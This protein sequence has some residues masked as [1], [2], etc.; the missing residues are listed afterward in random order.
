MSPAVDSVKYLSYRLLARD[1]TRSDGI[2]NLAVKV[3]LS[4]AIH[5]RWPGDDGRTVT[6]QTGGS[7]GTHEKWPSHDSKAI[8]AQTGGSS[9]THERWSSSNSRAETSQ[10]VIGVPEAIARVPEFHF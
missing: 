3:G 5:K 10:T 1:G 4:L 8:M 2:I 6:S 9:D 7:L